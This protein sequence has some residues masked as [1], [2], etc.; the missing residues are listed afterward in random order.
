MRSRLA[1][2]AALTLVWLGMGVPA[3]HAAPALTVT[4]LTWNVLGLDSN[5]PTT[6]PN[7]YPVG[8]RVCNKG[9]STASGVVARLVLAS[10]SSYITPTGPTSLSKGSLAPGACADAYFAVTVTRTKAAYDATRGVRI[11]ASA[12]GVPAVST[13]SPRE[14]YVE[15]LI[16]QNRNTVLSL[17]GPTTVYVGGTYRYTLVSQTAP[18]GYEQLENHIN[19]PPG[20]LELLHVATTYGTP[21][22][23]TNDSVYADA[24]GW[25]PVPT[26]ATYL[27]CVGPANYADGKAGDS[28]RTVY[29]VRVRAVG[30]AKLTGVVYDKSG[31]SYHYNTDY[32]TAS[33]RL[34]VTAVV[35]PDLSLTKT[36]ATSP[37][38]P[39]GTGTWTLT[40]RNVGGSATTGTT[41]V[42]DTVP[43]GATPVSATGS[44]WSCTISGR[45]VTC[46][47]SASI[48]PG[49][50]STIALVVRL[51]AD[52]P[53]TLPN[54]ATVRTPDDLNTAND[55]GR[56][57][58]PVASATSPRQAV[59]GSS[60]P[61]RTSA[62]VATTG[63]QAATARA[64]AAIGPRAG[65]TLPYTGAPLDQLLRWGV[66][67][68]AVG[69]VLLALG[70]RRRTTD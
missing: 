60:S 49:A 1:A 50:S 58:V 46:T 33:N 57:S 23:A 9:S 29:T 21:S 30:T 37:W 28:I 44:G 56:D 26:S 54:T 7:L 27:S 53:S 25:D 20:M 66:S 62:Q 65:G 16:S 35:P 5:D 14:L 70:Y 40:V 24:C 59:T 15:H 67:G 18:G 11:V 69:L 41:T 43:V 61:G 3:A 55:V 39:G 4:P 8:A 48:A 12:T 31:S 19:L 68:V 32:D 13:P 17:T 45:T 6:G 34:L 63:R 64:A 36:H 22:G 2:C 10:G 52:A 42:T 47:T 38:Q 51:D